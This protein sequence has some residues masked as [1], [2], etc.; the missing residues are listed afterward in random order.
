M[1][2]AYTNLQTKHD[3]KAQQYMLFYLQTAEYNNIRII[4]VFQHF[5]RI[6]LASRLKHALLIY[7]QIP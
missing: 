1:C 3:A 7:C 2:F 4:P 6:V 5:H